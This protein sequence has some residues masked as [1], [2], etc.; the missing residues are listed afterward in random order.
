VIN[1]ANGLGAGSAA[2]G[3][4]AAAAPAAAASVTGIRVAAY[5][6]AR[7]VLGQL[8][9]ADGDTVTVARFTGG[10]RFV[11]HC[12]TV[13]PGCPS[14]LPLK[15]GPAIGGSER[16]YL[17][18]A[19]NGGFKQFSNG[20]GVLQEGYVLRPLQN[21]RASLVIYRSGAAVIGTWGG[22]FP[23]DRSQVY[24]VRQ[25]LTLLVSKGQ[26]T[27]AAGDAALWGAT[28]TGQ[29]LV[30][31]SGLG[32]TASGQM[33]Y[34]ASMSATP[35]DLAQAMVASGVQTGMQL[36]INPEWVQLDY[37]QRA[38]APLLP[39]VPYQSRPADQYLVGWTRDFISVLATSLPVP[40]SAGTQIVPGG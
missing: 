21:G 17:I 38:G 25:N 37:A 35:V 19:F 22:G 15:A 33:I 6:P 39:G 9:L 18:A 30:A 27:Q 31:R 20:G 2:G 11:L 34:V 36:D 12:G 3:G 16:P 26:P 40:P 4:G 5:Q 7:V 24:S 8:T 23:P 28:V 10:V 13:D 29:A 14:A 32:Q 1:G